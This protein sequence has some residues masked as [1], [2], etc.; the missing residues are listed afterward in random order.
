MIR[1][2][3]VNGEREA[4]LEDRVVVEFGAIVE[5]DGFEIAAMATDR[6]GGCSGHLILATRA[7]LTDDRVPGLALDYGW[8]AMAP[9]AALHGGA[10][11]PPIPFPPS[12]YNG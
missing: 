5:R 7:Q 9:I 1:G 4:L 3:E 8:H 11:P 10:S 2:R 12:H 6:A